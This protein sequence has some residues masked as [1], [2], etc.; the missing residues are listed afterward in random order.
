VAK[1]PASLLHKGRKVPGCLGARRGRSNRNAHLH[2]QEHWYETCLYYTAEGR[3]L[4][5]LLLA[6]CA[7][8][9]KPIP[10]TLKTNVPTLC[11][12]CG[13]GRGAGL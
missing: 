5:A 7:R 4:M 12:K 10:G 11:D 6:L 9:G 13:S 2:E 3:C 8:C 1:G